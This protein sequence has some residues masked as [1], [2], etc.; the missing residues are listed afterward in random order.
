MIEISKNTEDSIKKEMVELNEK[1]AKQDNKILERPACAN[2]P[3]FLQASK[4]P[5]RR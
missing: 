3:K 4:S 5:C 1:I 2:L